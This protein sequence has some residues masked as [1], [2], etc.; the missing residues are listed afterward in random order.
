MNVIQ[1]HTTQEAQKFRVKIRAVVANS[2]I[3]KIQRIILRSCLVSF[4]AVQAA[5]LFLDARHKGGVLLHISGFLLRTELIDLFQ[6][7]D[8]KVTI[9]H[10]AGRLHQAQAD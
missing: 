1:A 5:I 10:Q 6:P 9:E 7:I 3:P 8:G 4:H 2:M